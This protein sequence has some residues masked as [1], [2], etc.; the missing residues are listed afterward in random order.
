MLSI[1]ALSRATHVPAETLRTWERR[2]GFPKP[3]ERSDSAHRRYA[4]DTVE[5]LRLVLQAIDLGHKPSVALRAEADALHA[6][7]RVAGEAAPGVGAGASPS[8]DPRWT[9]RWFSHV[10]R[11]DGEGLLDELERAWNAFGALPM[12]RSMLG[13]FLTELGERWACDSLDVAHEHFAS[14]QVREFLHSKWRP[15]SERARGP[16]VVCAT[17]PGERHV[18]GLHIAATVIALSGGQAIFLG[19]DTPPE[20]VSVAFS[21]RRGDAVALSAASG[22]DEAALRRG[23]KKL[24]RELPKKTPIVAGGAG[25]TR[26]YPGVE[27]RADLGELSAWVREVRS[28]RG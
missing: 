22:A 11:F 6:L 8:S 27:I 26:A 5:R 4:L 24:E 13:P 10:E 7:I 9:E 15:L 25:F 20:D 17:L 2:Y 1:G 23:V 12:L 21:A 16:R 3:L 19:A 14:E 28:R 18:L